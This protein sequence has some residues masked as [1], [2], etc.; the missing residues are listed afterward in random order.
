MGMRH[1]VR[2]KTPEEPEDILFTEVTE[3]A[4]A[5]PAGGFSEAVA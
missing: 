1:P 4:P 3:P 2:R 5:T